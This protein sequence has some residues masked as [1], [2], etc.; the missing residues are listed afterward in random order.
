MKPAAEALSEVLAGIEFAAP[1]IPV[2]QN[3]SGTIQ[4]EPEQIKE[5]LVRQLHMPVLWVDCVRAIHE[6]GVQKLVEVGPGRV[7]CGLVKRIVPELG[8]MSSEDPQDFD[9]LVMEVAG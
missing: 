5:N 4:T 6:A 1:G 9:S 7:L 2:V 8:C 3:V